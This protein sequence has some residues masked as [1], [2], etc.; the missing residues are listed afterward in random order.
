MINESEFQHP[1]STIIHEAHSETSSILALP[2]R[3]STHRRIPPMRLAY[4]A[5]DSS[6]WIPPDLITEMQH[7]YAT[8]VDN[9]NVTDFCQTR[10]SF[11]PHQTIGN[12][13]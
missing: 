3:R 4:R 13:L 1:Q 5:H 12:K 9:A 7:A 2:T 10:T 6:N 11:Y 8:E